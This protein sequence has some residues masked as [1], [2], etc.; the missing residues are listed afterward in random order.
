MT[1]RTRLI[2]WAVL[3]AAILFSGASEY[4][5]ARALLAGAEGTAW[6]LDLAIGWVYISV[7]LI[8]WARRPHSSMGPLMAAVGFAWFLA[9]FERSGVPLLASLGFGFGALH[10]GMTLHVVLAYPSGKLQRRIER[11]LFAVGY[12][13]LAIRGIVA[14]LFID[15]PP[16]CGDCPRGIAPWPSPAAETFFQ[17]STLIFGV[18]SVAFL[19]LLVRRLV[20]TTAMQR[21]ELIELWVAGSILLMLSTTELVMFSVDSEPPPAVFDAIAAAHLAI[22]LSLA[23]GIFRLQLAK[24]AVLETVERQRTELARFAPQA[25]DLLSS[26]EGEQLLAGHR[27]EITALFCDLRGFTAFAETAEPE[28]VLKVLRQYH[29]LVGDLVVGNKGVVEHFAGDGLMAFFNDPRPIP[30]HELAALRAAIAIRERFSR[31]AD[32]WR[33]RGYDLGL[34]M[35]IATGYATLGRIGFEGRYD[36][37]ATG[38]VVILAARLSDAASA[39]EILVSQ[40]TYAAAENHVITESVPELDL[41]G[42]SRP[43]FAVRAIAMRA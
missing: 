36:Y 29:T 6:W 1:P 39:N 7:G 26:D 11:V 24:A 25:A 28:E 32:N 41:K 42:F 21:R 4:V 18:L 16:G 30:N 35:G 19:A 43:I 20:N 3:V 23:A 14:V 31:L 13:A 27:R 2:W 17:R 38:T 9:N 40:R 12:S 37:G 15:R 22:P 34:G 33:K 8:M 10:I 5:R